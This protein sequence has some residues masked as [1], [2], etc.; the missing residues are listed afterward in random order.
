MSV[1]KDILRS[2]PKRMAARTSNTAVIQEVRCNGLNYMENLGAMQGT[3]LAVPRYG[4][5]SVGQTI[6]CVVCPAARVSRVLSRP[7]AHLELGHSLWGG[8]LVRG[9]LWVR[10]LGRLRFL[11]SA[12]GS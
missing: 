11:E 10:P 2:S 7:A 12:K 4:K 9:T 6:V 1:E 3:P 8:R 5:T